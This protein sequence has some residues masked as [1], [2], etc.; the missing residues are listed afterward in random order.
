VHLLNQ[1]ELFDSI[2]SK[3]QPITIERKTME[4]RKEEED[5]N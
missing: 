5:E 3:R 1:V 4:E 2:C